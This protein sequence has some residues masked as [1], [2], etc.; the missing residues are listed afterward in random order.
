[1]ARRANGGFCTTLNPQCHSFT[2]L[3]FHVCLVIKV[4]GR[5]DRPVMHVIGKCMWLLALVDELCLS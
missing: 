1:M 3:L 5:G 4:C 2:L